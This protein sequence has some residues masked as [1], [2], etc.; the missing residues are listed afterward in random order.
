MI[1]VLPVERFLAT[2]RIVQRESEHLAYSWRSLFDASPT[3]DATWVETLDNDPERA[4][5]LEAFVSRFGRMQD[6]IAGKLIPYWLQALA[7]PIASQIENLNRAER[8]GV[9]EDVER[10]LELRR[11]RNRLVHEYLERPEDF[12]EGLRVAR[13][14]SRM[15]F[16]AYNRIRAYAEQRMGIETDRLPLPASRLGESDS[17]AHPRDQTRTP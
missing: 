7:E 14:D 1:E 13:D 5:R 9:I 2:L 16:D 17:S 10:W 4:V 12:A 15:L 6:T 3:I 8:L 11:L